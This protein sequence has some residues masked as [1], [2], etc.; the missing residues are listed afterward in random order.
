MK[1]SQIQLGTK[2]EK[3]GTLLIPG[4]GEG[5]SMGKV[6]V[7]LRPLDAGEELA[8]IAHARTFA[9]DRGVTDPHMGDEL[10][11]SALF[12]YTL[13]T[14]VL[15]KDSPVGVRQ[16]FF[17]AGIDQVLSLDPDSIGHLYEQQQLWQEEC[18]PTI[19]TKT[20][21]DLL[22]LTRQIAEDESQGFF[23]RLSRSTQA[24]CARTMAR[25]LLASPEHSMLFG[26]PSEASGKTH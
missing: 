6:D 11:D 10:Y 17:D 13:V 3:P 5:G 23:L 9:M 14:A 12:V 18:S 15:D 22:K 8:V 26:P 21:G 24:T 1:F 20:A 19:R 2:A 25:L 4:A 7:L 16:P